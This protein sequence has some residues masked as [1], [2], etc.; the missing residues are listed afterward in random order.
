MS[1]AHEPSFLAH[2]NDVLAASA[3]VAAVLAA[4]FTLWQAEVQ[5]AIDR[6]A[7]DDPANWEKSAGPIA[8]ALWFRAMPLFAIATA[9]AGAL[10]PRAWGIATNALLCGPT[11]AYDDVQAIF[12]L[13]L[14]LIL[15]LAVMTV[16]QGLRLAC[17]LVRKK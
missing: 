13:T 9:T 15:G 1:C 2:M 14:A 3:L 8:H 17:R 16:V 5:A 11:C 12:L 10:W 7:S 6:E 4:F